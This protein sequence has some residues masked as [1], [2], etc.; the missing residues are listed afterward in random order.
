MAIDRAEYVSTCL[1]EWIDKGM[2][3]DEMTKVSGLIADVF[4]KMDA[5]GKDIAEEMTKLANPAAAAAASPAAGGFL[6]AALGLIPAGLAATGVA[7]LPGKLMS[8]AVDV[9]TSAA[10]SLG[11]YLPLALIGGPLAAYG[12]GSYGGRMLASNMDES[13]TAV[14]SLKNREILKALRD[15]TARLN[16]G[17]QTEE[18]APHTNFS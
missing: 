5:D 10:K 4:E 16:A 11:G 1:S 18:Q 2:T 14:K 8:S 9:G 13:S 6:D 15:E 17:R 7:G 12:L 3:L